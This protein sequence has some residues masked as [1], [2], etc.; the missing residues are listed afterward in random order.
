MPLQAARPCLIHVSS[1]NSCHSLSAFIHITTPPLSIQPS[2]TP[3][4]IHCPAPPLVMCASLEVGTGWGHQHSQA[5]QTARAFMAGA[6]SPHR[7]RSLPPRG[8]SEGCAPQACHAV[9]VAGAACQRRLRKRLSLSMSDQGQVHL[10]QL[11]SGR[12]G[13]GLGGARR[14]GAC[15]KAGRAGQPSCHSRRQQSWDGRPERLASGRR[16]TAGGRAAAATARSAPERKEWRMDEVT[17]LSTR[18][19]KSAAASL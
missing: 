10:C 6:T 8:L 1:P 4:L 7:R 3:P 13:R 2:L 5:G 9:R 15:R 17:L 19:M 18:G 11:P 12:K 14:G 16:Q